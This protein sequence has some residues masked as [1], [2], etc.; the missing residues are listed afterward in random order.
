M[1]LKLQKADATAD[2]AREQI[3]S[4]MFR[5]IHCSI[6]DLERLPGLKTMW[7]RK[8]KAYADRWSRKQLQITGKRSHADIVGAAETSRGGD[9]DSQD[10]SSEGYK[11]ARSVEV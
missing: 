5:F 1:V 3:D 7:V 8:L 11:K 6:A 2:D 4:K 9:E 10:A